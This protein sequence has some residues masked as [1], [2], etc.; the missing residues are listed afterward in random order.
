MWLN[1]DAIE[2][3]TTYSVTVN[4]FLASG[5]DNFSALRRR[6][7]QAGHR[8]D[9][10]AG[11]WSTTWPS[12]RQRRRSAVDYTQH[13]VGVTFPAGAPAS[14][15]VGDHVTFDLS[16]L[17]M[18]DP[19]DTRDAAVTVTLGSTTLGTFPV[20]TTLA[21]RRTPTAR[22]GRHGFRSTW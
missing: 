10:P 6:H 18:T 20:T 22:R 8:Q 9:R 2:P 14:Y 11:A 16:S 4:S 13:A 3:A 5:G 17:S 7:R 1:G 12:S 21:P 19:L 15:A